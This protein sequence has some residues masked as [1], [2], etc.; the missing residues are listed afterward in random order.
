MTKN[1]KQNKRNNIKKEQRL[2]HQ[3]TQSQKQKQENKKA[4]GVTQQ[5]I[6]LGFNSSRSLLVDNNP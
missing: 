1:K 2:V 3:H 5:T 6:Q 4:L